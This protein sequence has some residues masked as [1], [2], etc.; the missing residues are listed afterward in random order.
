MAICFFIIFALIYLSNIFV[1]FF[2]NL[3]TKSYYFAKIMIFSTNMMNIK[4]ILAR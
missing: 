4:A 2:N 1:D 3:S